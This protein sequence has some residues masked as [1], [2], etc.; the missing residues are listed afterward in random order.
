MR[1]IC[2]FPHFC[3]HGFCDLLSWFLYSL[4]GQ[5]FSPTFADSLISIHPFDRVCQTVA[6]LPY[7]GK[8][9][10]SSSWGI[11]GTWGIFPTPMMWN[12]A[13]LLKITKYMSEALF[14]LLSSILQDPTDYLAA[15]LGYL[16]TLSK[17]D[18]NISKRELLT[19][20]SLLHSLPA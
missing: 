13:Y 11:Q 3:L 18:H 19:P 9:R 17:R 6:F 7:S 10:I 4:I 20:F 15:S 14:F 5:R 16:I 12:N 2:L 1:S 8:R